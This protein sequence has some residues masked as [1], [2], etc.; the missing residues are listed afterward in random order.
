MTELN[1]TF[2]NNSN[3]IENIESNQMVGKTWS[4]QE[5]LL[6]KKFYLEDKLDVIKISELHQRTPG[7]IVA[8]LVRNKIIQEKKMA[9]G[10][11]TFSK[12]TQITKPVITPKTIKTIPIKL[13]EEIIKIGDQEFILSGEH[14]WGIK[15]IKDQIL[16]TY[17]KS[18]NQYTPFD[19]LTKYLIEFL[20][21]RTELKPN[22]L[23]LGN[24]LEPIKKYYSNDQNVVFWND[25]KLL[26]DNKI[27][28]CVIN[29]FFS[30]E[31]AHEFVKQIFD[32]DG[33][34]QQQITLLSLQLIMNLI[35]T[36]GDLILFEESNENMIGIVDILKQNNFSV[37]EEKSNQI[38]T[39]KKSP[40]RNFPILVVDT[41]T[42]GL[43]SS[44]DFRRIN[45]FDSARLIELGFILFDS[46]GNQV[47]KN[48]ILIRPNGFT[49][50]N[51]HIHGISHIE[52]VE[53]GKS[54]DE[55]LNEFEQILKTIEG[56]V[57]H[58]ITFDMNIIMSEAYRLK[59]H[60]L[61]ELIESKTK[62]CTMEMGK[63]FMKFYKNPKLV[64]LYK[65][66][67]NK[68]FNQEHRAL[69]DCEACAD[70][71]FSM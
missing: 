40:K 39:I 5:D 45:C 44:W 2:Q 63:K 35:E 25:P 29:N 49:I 11:E 67:F 13:P 30:S 53:K 3:D 58:N 16:G 12:P 43:P 42:T 47:Y 6:L 61:I 65:F 28:V 20:K 64:E 8:R 48:S 14:I 51:S 1:T 60:S 54:I 71:Y 22:I 33:L 70:C 24:N 15:K 10:W 26:N 50:E 46:N 19:S 27:N 34:N 38:I 69:S 62:I 7:G 23:L 21:S 37:I 55:V 36:N 17:D 66:I 59:K 68:E 18:N 41:E 31:L 57:C 52:A 9:R 32:N 4:E 56:I